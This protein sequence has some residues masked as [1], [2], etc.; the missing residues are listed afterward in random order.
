MEHRKRGLLL[1]PPFAVK[2]PGGRGFELAMLPI[3][4]LLDL[5]AAVLKNKINDSK[6]KIDWFD[7]TVPKNTSTNL[8]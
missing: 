1:L 3:G 6:Q 8:R 7:K 2:K 5:E 4:T